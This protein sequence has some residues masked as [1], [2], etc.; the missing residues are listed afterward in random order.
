MTDYIVVF[1]AAMLAGIS[2]GFVG[3]SAAVVMV[4][5]LI[6]MCPAFGSAEYG[7][8]AA[9]AI[10]LASDVIGSA[11]T[12]G[13]YAKNRRIDLKR[14]YLLLILVLTTCIAGSVAAYFTHQEVLG[15][16]TLFMCVV[17]GIRFIVKPQTGEGQLDKRGQKLT[18][19]E[20]VISVFFGLAIGFGTGFFGSGGGMMMLIVFT[21]FLGYDRKTA[22]GTSTFIMTFTALIASVSHII[23]EPHVISDYW[24]FFVTGI[25][26]ETVF[27]IVCA[28]F[29]N[30][31]DPKVVGLITGILLTVLGV[32]LIFLN[33]RSLF[34]L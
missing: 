1:I 30:K 26:V 16:L 32:V 34:G 31:A 7:V 10:A 12:A 5:L 3:L 8:F 24:Q 29:A 6:V 25:A 15:G 11:V 23:I 9:T 4:P 22:V 33:Y 18:A 13:V 17:I 14:A 20:I 19:K 28:Q 21:V 2:T 27:S